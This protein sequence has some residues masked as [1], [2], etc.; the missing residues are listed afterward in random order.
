MITLFGDW[1]PQ[2]RAIELTE[3]GIKVCNLECAF[4][5]GNVA[6]DKAYSCVVSPSL[7]KQ[8]ANSGFAALSVA[9]N[10][11][12]DAGPETF[13]SFVKSLVQANDRL[14]IFGTT[15]H[16]Y[17]VFSPMANPD[18]PSVV[19]IG[20]LE[21]CRSRG[22]KIFKEEDVL[23]LVKRLR[24]G[25][26]AI[27]SQ[28]PTLN[29]IIFIYPHWGK[30][31]EFTRWP[32]PRQRKLARKWIDAGA[33]GV[34]GS[35][36]HVFQGCEL[37]RGKPIYYSL[38]NFIFPHPESA[39]YD[40]THDGLSVSIDVS[41]GSVCCRN[42]FH[43]F[44]GEGKLVPGTDGAGLLQ[45]ISKPLSNWT[46][47]KWARAI[48]GFYIRKN[49]ASWKIRLSRK[50]GLKQRV[51]TI[52]KFLVWSVLPQTLLFCMAGACGKGK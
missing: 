36:S 20:C 42:E 51:T 41:G 35:H 15:D 12:Y 14:Q 48:G 8:V 33:D 24:S 1:L 30:E 40:G 37:Y 46:I 39:K 16:P 29:P 13:D 28:L 44:D 5:G 4:S 22:A 6:N 25:H 34:V 49:M 32:S 38:G 52:A 10:H 21:P 31:S 26:T 17:A 3:P 19:V 45:E 2:S 7:I 23:G 11:A 47:W 43:G 18:S 9:N 50:M 27:D